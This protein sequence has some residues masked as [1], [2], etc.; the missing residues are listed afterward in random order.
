MVG[1]ATSE[2]A[3]RIQA[4]MDRGQLLWKWGVGW[5]SSVHCSQEAWEE[6]A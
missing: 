1:M 3:R 5:G 4:V 6:A 2:G